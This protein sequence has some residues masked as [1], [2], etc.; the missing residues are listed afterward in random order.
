MT[1][2]LH[3]VQC[4]DCS[5]VV[6][7]SFAVVAHDGKQTALMLVA[8]CPQCHAKGDKRS[9]RNFEKVDKKTLTDALEQKLPIVLLR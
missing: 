3:K 1:D 5:G 2:E 9:L 6:S 7:Y 4:P 8:S